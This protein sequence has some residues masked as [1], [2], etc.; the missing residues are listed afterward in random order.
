MIVKI[1]DG[2][3]EKYNTLF[4][5]AY[6]YLKDKKILDD[7]NLVEIADEIAFSNYDKLYYFDDDAQEH[8]EAEE[9]V[10]GKDY[11]IKNEKDSFSSLPEYYSHMNDFFVNGGWKYVFLPLD[12]NVFNINLN[13]RSIAI[14]N[15]FSRQVSVQSDHLAEMIIFSVDR[16]F[17]YMDLANTN[18]YV[19]WET[20]D[21]TKSATRIFMIDLS[22]S[23]KIRFAWPISNIITANPGAVKFSVRFF[24][25]NEEKQMVYSL[26]TTE[27]SFN[28]SRAHQNSLNFTN[29]E[30][31]ENLFDKV[32]IN[33]MYADEGTSLPLAPSFLN[34]V[35][36]Y[37]TLK[38]ADVEEADLTAVS[39]ANLTDDSLILCAEANT[40][41]AGELIYTWYYLSN[42]PGA[43]IVDLTNNHNYEIGNIMVKYPAPKNENDEIDWS[44]GYVPGQRYYQTTDIASRI[45]D[46]RNCKDEF[47]YRRYST[48]RILPNA[49]S[50]TNEVVG[51]YYV[52]AINKI[53]SNENPNP[54]NSSTCILPAPVEVT[55]VDNLKENKNFL[56]NGK[57]ALTITHDEELQNDIDEI[58]YEW[59]G[60]DE[61]GEEIEISNTT[62]TY[63][64]T[65]NGLYQVK[66][67]AKANRVTTDAVI[68]N[69]AKVTGKP[70]APIF[71]K[72]DSFDATQ[73]IYDLNNL[74]RYESLEEIF[75]ASVPH[76]DNEF[77]S[78]GIQYQWYY[79][80]IDS[81]E[82][83]E[84]IDNTTNKLTIT[85]D[86]NKGYYHCVAINVLNGETAETHSH[87]VGMVVSVY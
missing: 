11:F 66:L 9:Y 80:A 44:V 19:Q 30:Y 13:N 61:D 33:S 41:D 76:G 56:E 62:A 58:I 69:V 34:K 51:Q 71:D 31:Q 54:A 75:N 49:D 60:T 37:K 43:K 82:K 47:L 70:S 83:E 12:E 6:K 35:N 84:K 79:N 8:K 78:E 18:I 77:Y 68:S 10:S 39:E 74:N 59:L 21:G 87:L 5:E 50:A 24:R 15:D 40:L 4:V 29:V 1:T 81:M 23:D 48:L 86:L 67:S 46:I 20:P 38:T 22:D 25:T 57:C 7:Y 73:H 2:I 63:E 26:N 53:A 72:A 28:I 45:A 85:K 17:D 55:I 65:K 32:I 16:Y 36:V 52:E 64:A 14:P 42:Q 27:Y 3:R